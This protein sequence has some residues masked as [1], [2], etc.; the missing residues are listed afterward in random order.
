MDFTDF[1][2]IQAFVAKTSR[3][4]VSGNRVYSVGLKRPRPDDFTVDSHDKDDKDDNGD[5]VF[6]AINFAE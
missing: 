3:L 6:E 5:F 1:R 4:S 2:Q